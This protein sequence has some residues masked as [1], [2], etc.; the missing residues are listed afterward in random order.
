MNHGH[1]FPGLILLLVLSCILAAGC[2]GGSTSPPA[3][4]ASPSPSATPGPAVTIATVP[5][6]EMALQVY[7]LP[8]GYV[9]RDRTALAYAGVG[10]VSRDLGW[11]Q[12]YRVSFYRLDKDM[13]DMTSITQEVHVFPYGSIN[14]VY[15]LE[16]DALLPP[17]DS[18]T[19]YQIPFPQLADRSI[20]WREVHTGVTGSTVTY[21]VIF[22]EKNVFEKIAMTGTTT[23]YEVL[24]QVAWTAAGKVR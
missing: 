13:D 4:P 20:A 8:A 9:L 7:E 5:A 10:Q 16:K 24:K 6:A 11:R 17:D 22:T 21:T 12:G 18:A 2:L 19:D 3:A 15:L 1:G 23:D 14:E